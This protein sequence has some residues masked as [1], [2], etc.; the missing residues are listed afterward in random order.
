M[1]QFVPN[2]VVREF[3]YSF[4]RSSL[5][6]QKFFKYRFGK[7]YYAVSRFGFCVCFFRIVSLYENKTDK[8]LCKYSI[9]AYA[10]RI[11]RYFFS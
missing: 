8:K 11:L 3:A 1:L 10:P 9:I 4:R 7:R 6:R 5:E 2:L